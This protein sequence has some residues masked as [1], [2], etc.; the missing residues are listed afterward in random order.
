MSRTKI[1][2]LTLAAAACILLIWG[3]TRRATP[4]RIPFTRVARATVISSLSTN[5]KVE[6]IEWASARAE[7]QGVV[8]QV[9]VHQGDHVAQGAR[10]VSM[11]V[12]TAA[13]DLAAAE[14]QIAT[15]QAQQQAVRAGGPQSERTQIQ[16]ELAA[17]RAGLKNAQREYDSLQRLVAKQAATRVEL[18]GARQRVEQGQIQ[19]QSLERRQAALVAPSDAAVAQARFNEAQ[20]AAALARR[21]L[22]ESIVRAPVS[23]SVYQF[24]LRV[25]SYLNPGDLVANIG[26]LEEVRVTVYVDEPDLGRVDKGMPVTITWDALP[27][28]QWK[29]AVEKLPTQ[30]VALGSR[31]VGEVS[32]IIDNPDRDLLPGTNV[33]AEIQSRVVQNAISIPK[34]AIRREGDVSGVYLLQDERVLW[35]P[36]KL[37]VSS[38]TRTQVVQGLAEG[39]AVALPTDR[40]LKNDM[41]VT[42]TYP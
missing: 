37:G 9:F 22:S 33:N 28:R 2:L 6:P 29:G 26:R 40:T 30:I 24:D 10:L 38:Y 14:A 7:Q 41:R 5:G 21:N 8:R 12:T 27:G 32:C 42:P 31:Q 15:A 25:G 36:V 39:Q 11:E 4:P 13:S 20:S 19:I 35:R 3:F 17:A 23:G 1:I 18:E 34:E 16:N